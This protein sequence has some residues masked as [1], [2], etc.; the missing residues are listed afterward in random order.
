MQVTSRTQRHPINPSDQ[1]HDV[2]GMTFNAGTAGDYRSTKLTW[3]TERLWLSH[4]NAS[5]K[6]A[7]SSSDV[8]HDA[9]K[10]R[11]TAS[12]GVRFDVLGRA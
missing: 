4:L 9:A 5:K 10:V 8:L 1:I 12:L 6:Q 11:R 7:P 3:Q 2:A